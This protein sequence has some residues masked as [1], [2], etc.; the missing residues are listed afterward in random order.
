MN[1]ACMSTAIQNGTKI[2]PQFPEVDRCANLSFREFRR[3]Y[4][5]PR[6]PVVITGAIENWK[7]R[8]TW[9]MDYFKSRYGNYDITVYQLGGERYTAAGAETMKLSTFIERV[10]RK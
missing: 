7:A 3:E 10:E 1:G 8:A 4:L 5:Y 9:T 6:K 2:L